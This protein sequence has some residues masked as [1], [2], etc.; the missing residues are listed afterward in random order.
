MEFYSRDIQIMR[1]SQ[2][3]MAFEYVESLGVTVS[4]EEL[5]RITDIFVEYC[6]RPSDDDLKKRVKALDVWLKTKIA[7]NNQVK[8]VL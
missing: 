5:Q 3:K 6:I 8:N 1:Q 7:S 2:T 4:V